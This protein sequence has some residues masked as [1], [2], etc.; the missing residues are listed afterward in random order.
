[1]NPERW[2]L[3]RECK[4]YLEFDNEKY[5]DKLSDDATEEIKSKWDKFNKIPDDQIIEREPF[6]SKK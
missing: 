3:Y 1:M 4:P 5:I 6:T 2:R